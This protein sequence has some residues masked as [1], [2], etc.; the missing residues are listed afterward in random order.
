MLKK[1]PTD[2]TIDC[3]LSKPDNQNGESLKPQA[4]NHPMNKV[5]ASPWISKC[6]IALTFNPSS[7]RKHN[8][9]PAAAFTHNSFNLYNPLTYGE[10]S[11]TALLT[12]RFKSVQNHFNPASTSPRIRH[13]ENIK[14]SDDCKYRVYDT[15]SCDKKIICNSLSLS[16]KY[17]VNLDKLSPTTPNPVFK[18]PVCSKTFENSKILNVS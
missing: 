17:V 4:I 16:E 12:S 2:F 13:Q 9:Q 8:F 7:H 15:E 6:P 11:S 5:L 14:L 3:I 10:N 1:P 18:C